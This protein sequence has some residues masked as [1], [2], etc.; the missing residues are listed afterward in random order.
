VFGE[1][2]LVTGERR[3]ATVRAL[4]P[5][6]LIVVG[7]APFREVLGKNPELV[8][9]ISEVLA[10][11]QAEIDQARSARGVGDRAGGSSALLARIRRFFSLT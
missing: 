9:R 11:R 3:S 1:M 6:E 8:Q 10:S 5:S 4:R 2:S 7:H